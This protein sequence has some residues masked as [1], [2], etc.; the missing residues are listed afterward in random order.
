MQIIISYH[1]L[2]LKSSRSLLKVSIISRYFFTGFIIIKFLGVA[3]WVLAVA[4]RPGFA[5]SVES[6]A[7]ALQPFPFSN[8]GVDR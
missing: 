5:Y 8:G 2:Q 3:E 4:M 1:L 6:V 7:K